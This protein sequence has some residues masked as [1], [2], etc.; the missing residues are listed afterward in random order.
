MESKFS[1]VCS[2]DVGIQ[3]DARPQV[4]NAVVCVYGAR[5]AFFFFFTENR[6]QKTEITNIF[7]GAKYQKTFGMLY[8]CRVALKL[9]QEQQYSIVDHISFLLQVA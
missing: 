4:V 5:E 8:G 3:R 9:I 1:D 6:K 7:S 2:Y